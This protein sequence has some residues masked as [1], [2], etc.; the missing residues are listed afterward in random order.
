MYKG[1]VAFGDIYK[2]MGFGE[3]KFQLA[4]ASALV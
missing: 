4:I 3:I 1:M 2:A